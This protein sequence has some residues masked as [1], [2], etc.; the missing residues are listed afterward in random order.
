MQFPRR[1]PE[2]VRSAGSMCRSGVWAELTRELSVQRA[3]G[4]LT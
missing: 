1:S 2:A 4:A 3:E